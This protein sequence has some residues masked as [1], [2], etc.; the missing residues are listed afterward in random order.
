MASLQEFAVYQGNDLI[1]IGTAK[2]CAEIL[3]IK[4]SSVR[5]QTTP[6]AQKRLE[7]RKHPDRCRVFIKI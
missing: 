6:T 4:P 1:C 5:W 2:E 3:N 7:K